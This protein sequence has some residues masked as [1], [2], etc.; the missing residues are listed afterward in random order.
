MQTQQAVIDWFDSTYRR[1]G[2]RYLRPVRAYFVFL[3]LLGARAEHR[4]LDVACGPGVLLRAAS[5]YTTKLHGIDISPVAIAHGREA[6]PTAELTVGNAERLPYADAAFDLIT[7]LGS[8]ERM[9][10]GR[11]VLREMRRVGAPS[12]KYCFLVRNANSFGWKWWA[13]I[14]AQY[15][16]KGHAGADTLA[17]WQRLFESEGFRVTGVLPDQYPLHRRRHWSSLALRPVDFRKPIRPDAPL[18]RA[19]EFVF[20]LEKAP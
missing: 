14:T 7:C 18:E 6:I 5:E 9:L 8:L 19:N 10:D 13:P 2:T 12:A 11:Q 17:N 1:K 20:L 3:E 16:T 15:R 4:L